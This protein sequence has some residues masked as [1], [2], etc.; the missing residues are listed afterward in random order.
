MPSTSPSPSTPERR[1]DSA[2]A[3]ASAG[4]KRGFWRSLKLALHQVIVESRWIVPFTLIIGAVAFGL[5]LFSDLQRSASFNDRTVQVHQ[6]T[7]AVVLFLPALLV[8]IIRCRGWR[9]ILSMTL[10]CVPAALL[11][12]LYDTHL[13]GAVAMTGDY[14]QV[15]V[16]GAYYWN[17]GLIAIAILSPI[18]VTIAYQLT[19]ILDRHLIR[20]FTLPFI[21]CLVAFYSIW[22]IFDLND[23]LSDFREHR[24]SFREILT[25]YGIQ[26]PH[27]F[28]KVAQAAVLIATVYALSKMSQ[29]NEFIAIMGSGRSLMRTLTPL[30]LIGAY[31]SFLFLVF[32]YQWAPTGEGQKET[33]LDQFSGDQK[34]ASAKRHLF[35]NR[36]AGRTW[37]I[38]EIPLDPGK[39]E[40]RIVQIQFH[41]Q[42]FRLLRSIIAASATWN[43]E[44]R[45]WQFKDVRLVDHAQD[46]PAIVTVAT[47]QEL[48]WSETPWQLVNER[49]DPDYLGVPKLLSY[50]KT[51]ERDGLQT[52]NAILTNLHYRWAAPWSCLTILFLAAP[53]GIAYSRRGIFGGVASA[54]FLFGAILFL[55]EL[56]LALGKSG[57][58]DPALASWL[59]N[60]VFLILG[61]LFLYLRARN[62][63]VRLPRLRPYRLP[64]SDTLH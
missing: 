56:S 22:L 14:G 38:G 58:L 32:N 27:I 28:T 59:T 5:G 8:L 31:I 15:P 54:V 50:K 23:N 12:V 7:R 6:L 35:V 13:H 64:A 17:V 51:N 21:F 4:I 48:D 36:D 43:P 10:L 20:E 37:Y 45:I 39:E 53:L 63:T 18:L 40:L 57:H 24:P 61:G 19:T 30:F 60:T 44:T 1:S 42:E 26:I 41:D 11:W 34:T 33:L 9:Q 16:P 52:P 2:V 29:A 3:N 55:T 25:F 62:R 49:T 47:H 46:P